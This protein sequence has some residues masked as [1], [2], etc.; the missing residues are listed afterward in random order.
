MQL[1]VEGARWLS[2][3]GLARV[4]RRPKE[5]PGV[6]TGSVEGEQTKRRAGGAADAGDSGQSGVMHGGAGAGA[7]AKAGARK[8]HAASGT[9]AKSK[10]KK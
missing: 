2:L 3:E 5:R 1:M 6:P 9:G 4:A 8:P 10:K 7:G